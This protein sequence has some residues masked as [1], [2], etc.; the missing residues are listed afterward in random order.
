MLA[1]KLLILSW[2]ASQLLTHSINADTISIATMNQEE[3]K[4]CGIDKLSTE[5]KLSLD[6]WLITKLPPAAPVTPASQPKIHK[7]KILHGD[8]AVTNTVQL[9][10]FITL[11]NGVTYDIPS[12]S[13]KKTM[14]WKVGDKVRLVEPVIPVNYKLEN[15][16]KKQTIGAKIATS[17]KAPNESAQQEIAEQSANTKE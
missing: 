5:E 9:G 14:A 11:D 4:E 3:Q 16:A 1:K 15:I 6:M 7:H 13:R 17:K 2:V 10:R 8:F 12:R